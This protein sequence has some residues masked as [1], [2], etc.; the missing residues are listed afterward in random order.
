MQIKVTIRHYLALVK[1]L[2]S[3]CQKVTNAGK[4]IEKGKFLYTVGGTVSTAIYIFMNIYIF[5]YTIYIY[6]IYILYIYLDILYMLYL[7]E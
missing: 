3:K 6:Y 7:K 5:I 1:W 2:V 4:D